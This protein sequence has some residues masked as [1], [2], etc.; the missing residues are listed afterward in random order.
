MPIITFL[1]GVGGGWLPERFLE[2]KKLLSKK[3]L[4]DFIK[5]NKLQ[6]ESWAKYQREVKFEDA[7][8]LVSDKAASIEYLCSYLL[9]TI[10]Q[11]PVREWVPRFRYLRTE[12]SE[13]EHKEQEGGEDAVLQ[14][15]QE[16][17]GAAAVLQEENAE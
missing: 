8:F 13:G 11:N 1:E 17:Q 12:T 14:L 9:Y 5:A 7:L 15:L 4:V 3:I 2:Q 6:G 10:H 16:E